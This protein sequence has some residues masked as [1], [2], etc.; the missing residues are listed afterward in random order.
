MATYLPKRTETSA[1]EIHGSQSVVPE[2]APDKT[3]NFSFQDQQ[4]AQPETQDE[5]GEKIPR[6]EGEEEM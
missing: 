4:A 6:V 5:E 1:Y 3:S 2:N